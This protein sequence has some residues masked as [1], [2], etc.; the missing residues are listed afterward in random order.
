M[1]CTTV[2]RERH[3]KRS[4]LFLVGLRAG[5]DDM[6]RHLGDESDEDADPDKQVEHREE[7]SSGSLGCDVAITNRGE[8]DD[9]EV[10]TVKPR[11]VFNL[12]IEERARPDQAETGEHHR[13][14]PLIG[15]ERFQTASGNTD[16]SNETEHSSVLAADNS[17][18][19]PTVRAASRKQR[20]KTIPTV[21]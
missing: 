15:H 21:P 20:R 13:P 4:D 16:E 11:Q 9:R 14:R 7:L 19:R 1:T 17:M 10:E 8:R 12:V 18:Q 2:R 5:L 3:R 6:A